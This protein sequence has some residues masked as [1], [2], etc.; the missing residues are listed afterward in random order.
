MAI[1]M[2]GLNAESFKKMS[3]LITSR[4]M[5]KTYLLSD[6]GG[7]KMQDLLI[8]KG[9][10]SAGTVNNQYLDNI[11]SNSSTLDAI[12]LGFLNAR[13]V[14]ELQ[15]KLQTRVGN[16]TETAFNFLSDLGV[17][18]RSMG[19]RTSS[20]IIDAN[21]AEA[22]IP[23][24]HRPEEVAV[25]AS[26]LKTVDQS[27]AEIETNAQLA[28]KY[29]EY[30]TELDISIQNSASSAGRTYDSS[31]G[32]KDKPIT[33]LGIKNFDD[34]KK[35]YR[36]ARNKMGLNKVAT[37]LPWVACG[38][39]VVGGAAAG[40]TILGSVLFSTLSVGAI[41]SVI[42]T[43]AV[44]GLLAYGGY[45][46]IK[47]GMQAW[48]NHAKKKFEARRND[49]DVL[50]EKY[51]QYE[52]ENR[53]DKSRTKDLIN[54][55]AN[56]ATLGFAPLADMKVANTTTNV[57]D[58][59]TAKINAIIDLK[60]YYI[61]LSLDF[62]SPLYSSSYIAAIQNINAS[63]TQA[64][65]DIALANGKTE[66]DKLAK[67]PKD[68]T[69][70]EKKPEEKKPEEKKPEEKKPEEKKPEEKK[71]KEK[72]PE[73]KKPEEKKPKEKKPEEKTFDLEEEKE[74]AKQ[75][76]KQNYS[77]N[78][79]KTKEQRKFDD[80]INAIDRA[81]NKEELEEAIKEGHRNTTK[82]NADRAK[83]NKDANDLEESNNRK[84]KKGNKEAKANNLKEQ[85]EDAVSQ[86]KEECKKQGIDI[87][88]IN[89]YFNNIKNAQDYNGVQK[90]YF[91][92]IEIIGLRI[93][94]KKS[95]SKKETTK[96]TKQTE[97]NI[98]TK[99]EQ[100]KKNLDDK[101]LEFDAKISSAQSAL[102]AKNRELI[103]LE[104]ELNSYNFD[105]KTG[106][107]IYDN[108]TQGQRSSDISN[109]YKG[110]S[111]ADLQRDIKALDLVLYDL[112]TE[113]AKLEENTNELER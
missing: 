30:Q 92:A 91:A 64:E 85:K 70:E 16:T 60:N 53:H 80:A 7:H 69:K 89:S 51:F 78:A 17:I 62:N 28:Q 10:L 106:K 57:F 33:D 77:E 95:N 36:K 103:D 113:K 110:P 40:A 22:I 65:I 82:T 112:R 102:N 26:Q 34:Y 72:K 96:N 101:I 14:A 52:D 3:S 39:L 54:Q 83:E 18:D 45:K 5:V 56:D 63:T 48:R 41:G 24:Y 37:Y 19:D 59:Q 66:A 44:G 107:A 79:Q 42:G 104:K 108:N 67:K 1:N 87:A 98:L 55:K 90:N 99:S 9:V 20:T 84:N 32:S 23:S 75:K 71:P 4:Q 49:Y 97:K 38:G 47:K 25:F 93:E 15:K 12:G 13:S 35:A 68:K 21:Y 29:S 8:G 27:G 61:S 105:E 88:E 46:L 6:N 73:E 2:S 31:E 100:E 111:K 109:T 86:L 81:K 50:K 11:L 94:E 76:M 74:K 58:L 43:F